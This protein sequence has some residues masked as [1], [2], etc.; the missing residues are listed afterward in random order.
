VADESTAKLTVLQAP[1]GGWDRKNSPEQMA[2][3]AALYFDNVISTYGN[4]KARKG[5]TL[6]FDA[7][8]GKPINTIWPY[9]YNGIQYLMAATKD[10]LDYARIIKISFVKDE[11]G[12]DTDKL[13]SEDI[14]PENYYLKEDSFSTVQFRGKVFLASMY[15]DDAALVYDGEKLKVCEFVSWSPDV[16]ELDLTAIH[17]PCVHQQ[18]LYFIERGSTRVW[19][20]KSLGAVAGECAW[21][22]VE[23]FTA[24][25]GEIVS[26]ATWSRTGA[27]SSEPLLCVIT[28][29]G[30]LMLY[31]GTDPEAPDWKMISKTQMPEV[32]GVRNTANYRDDVAVMTRGGLFSLSG[33]AGTTGTFTSMADKDVALTDTIIGAIRT[34]ENSFYLDNWQVIYSD[35]Y[36]WLIINIPLTSTG[37]EQYVLNLE[38]NTWSR[39]T[40]IPSCCYTAFRY[41]MYFGSTDGKIYTFNKGGSDNGASIKVYIQGAYQM[42][43]TPYEKRI[44]E[45]TLYM[46]SA[47]RKK[48][49]VNTIVDYKLQ[50]VSEIMLEGAYGDRQ[51]ALWNKTKWNTAYWGSEGKIEDMDIIEVRTPMLT[52]S[53][54]RISVGIEYDVNDTAESD[55]VWASTDIRWEASQR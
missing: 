21:F 12:N 41:N 33:V 43:D 25:G 54:R 9:D 31:S 49:Y 35:A 24:R 55:T 22:D 6:F 48:L 17:K 7:S 1:L 5:Y 40:G 26:L 11:D 52:D 23:M 10:T 44:R 3:N 28:S 37:Y 18:R 46:F 15:G 47:F 45:L 50:G 38:N 20:T 19:Y 53:G 29:E 2:P 36:H 30:E 13:E 42:F 27:D 32:I 39:F 34:L 16:L 4:V 51:I 14:K 8:W